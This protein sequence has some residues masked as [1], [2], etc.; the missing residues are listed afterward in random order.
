MRRQR[1][2][3]KNAKNYL[4]NFIA[5]IYAF[6][7]PE[8]VILGGSVAL[9][10]RGFVEEVEERVKSKVYDVIETTCEST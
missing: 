4:A 2:L 7:D 5:F 9:K 10:D 8:I 3:W 1:P 6:A